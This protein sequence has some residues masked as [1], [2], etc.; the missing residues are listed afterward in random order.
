ML[1][2][3]LDHV[4]RTVRQVGFHDIFIGSYYCTT[5]WY[6]VVEFKK[7]AGEIPPPQHLVPARIQ[8]Q[9]LHFWES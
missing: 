7:S 6:T 3:L 4:V 5:G 9:F 2:M 8:W 1:N